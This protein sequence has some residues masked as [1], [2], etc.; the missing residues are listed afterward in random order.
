MRQGKIQ[1]E[2]MQGVV[3]RLEKDIEANQENLA[4]LTGTYDEE[5][6]K[7]QAVKASLS[8]T[9]KEKDELTR[10][11]AASEKRREDAQNENFERMRELVTLRND[12][13]AA[14][15]EEEQLHRRLA[16]MKEKMDLA[17]D[18]VKVR[19]NAWQTAVQPLQ[20]QKPA[21]ACQG[22]GHGCQSPS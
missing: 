21:G 20:T 22:K 19:Q 12:L 14:H 11:V 17:E 4:L 16:Q 3:A 15:Q 10:L 9:E 5:E 13:N 1:I 18:E 6:A 8:R 7:Y 2:Q